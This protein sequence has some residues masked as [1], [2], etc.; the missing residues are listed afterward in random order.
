[1]ISKQ[2]VLCT[3]YDKSHEL[4]HIHIYVGNPWSDAISINEHIRYVIICCLPFV[5]Y[6]VMF[7]FMF[8]YNASMILSFLMLSQSTGIDFLVC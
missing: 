4:H 8:C 6:F 5:I 3:E 1:V 2:C 7:Y